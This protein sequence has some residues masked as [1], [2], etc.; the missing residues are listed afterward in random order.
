MVGDDTGRGECRPCP[1]T[2]TLWVSA[3]FWSA[4]EVAAVDGLGPDDQHVEGDD[5]QAPYRVVGQPHEVQYGAQR[6]DGDAHRAGPD[7]AVE[8]EESGDQHE[9]P[10]EQVDPAPGGEVELEDPFLADDVEVVI[11][12]GDQTLQSVERTDHD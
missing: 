5:D 6:G 12:Q 2:F 10:D 1:V 4:G 7:C 8:H 11:E 3:P 9:H